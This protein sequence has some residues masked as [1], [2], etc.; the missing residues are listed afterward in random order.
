M[1]SHVHLF[2]PE[3]FYYKS[4]IIVVNVVLLMKGYINS[5][6]LHSLRFNPN[7]YECLKMIN[8][9]ALLGSSLFCGTKV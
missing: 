8:T 9:A 3:G 1:F 2:S 6:V 5:T 4:W 7:F